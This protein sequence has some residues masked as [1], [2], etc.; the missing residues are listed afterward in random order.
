LILPFLAIIAAAIFYRVFTAGDKVAGFTSDDAVYLLLADLYMF[1]DQAQLPVYTLIREQSLFPPLF[2]LLLGLLGGGSND[3]VLAGIIS[4][5]LLLSSLVVA[6]RWIL[7]QTQNLSFTLFLTGLLLLLPGTLILA[8]EIWS[9]FLF[10]LLLY[11]IFL[12]ADREV[13]L[14]HHW[15][16]MA[17]LIALAT[18]TRTAGVALIPPFLLLLY[19]N[20]I[21]PFWLPAAISTLPFIAW[22]VPR[23]VLRQSP[24][25]TSVLAAGTIDVAPSVLLGGLPAKLIA[26]FDSLHWLFASVDSGAA[27]FWFG[28]ILLLCMLMPAASVLVR[29]LISFRMD[30]WFCLVYV[31]I[32]LIWPHADI[33]F[34]SRFLYLLVPVFLLYAGIGLSGLIVNRGV[35]RA[36]FITL[37]LAVIVVTAPSVRQFTQRATAN[38]AEELEPYR[39]D[40]TWLL[41][42][43]A[44]KSILQNTRFIV[45]TL[46]KIPGEVQPDECIYAFQAP[47]VMLYTKRVTGALPSPDSSDEQFRQDT[48]LCRYILALP[49]SDAGRHMPEYYPLR[50]LRASAYEQTAYYMDPQARY[51]TAIYLLRR[52]TDTITAE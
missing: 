19:R 12:I 10:M 44:N 39:R 36:V 49:V 26:M 40:R 28:R 8:Q 2:P 47:L 50:R 18:L 22:Y 15:L 14:K 1:A 3:P 27:H 34:V 13:P 52:F 35:K 7:Q 25:Y 21:T 48:A 9:E 30:A 24:G 16:I 5:G 11:G 51:G 45:D 29:R 41:S 20:R 31:S 6:G 37:V 38:V 23:E 33:Y 32:I 46:Q 17:I 43:E 4:T 42:A